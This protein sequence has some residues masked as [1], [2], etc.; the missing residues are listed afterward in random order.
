MILFNLEKL[1]TIKSITINGRVITIA[2]IIIE[3]EE[4]NDWVKS[5]NDIFEINKIVLLIVII[6]RQIL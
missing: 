3:K 1:Q 2:A 4:E 6:E 5:T